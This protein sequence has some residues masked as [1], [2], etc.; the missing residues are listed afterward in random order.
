MLNPSLI[1]VLS[2]FKDFKLIAASPQV[3]N[4]QHFCS[5]QP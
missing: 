3:N 1:C 2:Q 5:F 4:L